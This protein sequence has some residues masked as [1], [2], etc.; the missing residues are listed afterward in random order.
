MGIILT[1]RIS[2]VHCMM[3]KSNSLLYLLALA[4]AAAAAQHICQ[5]AAT[6]SRVG[7]RNCP[8]LGEDGEPGA[9]NCVTKTR[10]Y[11]EAS[12]KCALGETETFD[13]TATI[14]PAVGNNVAAAEQT[15]AS[16]IKYDTNTGRYSIKT[17]QQKQSS[18]NSQKPYFIV[19]KTAD[20]KLA[21]IRFASKTNHDMPY[22]LADGD[23][24]YATVR[25]DY[26][27]A[28]ACVKIGKKVACGVKKQ[29]LKDTYRTTKACDKDDPKAAG[30]VKLSDGP[31]KCPAVLAGSCLKQT[32]CGTTSKCCKGGCKTMTRKLAAMSNMAKVASL[33]F[34]SMEP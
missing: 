28:S 31:W 22:K 16:W 23:G 9:I 33:T 34:S 17:N 7:W 13:A 27:K 6:S 29:I 14:L 25:I 32:D 15:L 5:E 19:G 12:A 10:S 24:G 30:C 20:G 26:R 2:L 3:K 4:V 1:R 11:A 8:F 18:I 21:A